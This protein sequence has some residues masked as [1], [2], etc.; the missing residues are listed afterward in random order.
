MFFVKV[1]EKQNGKLTKVPMP[2]VS[3]TF[4]SCFFP[5][6]IL[7]FSPPIF[8]KCKIAITVQGQVKK[9]GPS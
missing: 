2:L 8:P 9:T 1:S 5:L 4:G 6:Y 3:S 7:D